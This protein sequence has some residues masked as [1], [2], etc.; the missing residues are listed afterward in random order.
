MAEL[1]ELVSYSAAAWQD[2]GFALEG[3]KSFVRV[4]N[5]SPEYDPEFL[6][7]GLINR[8]V[9][10]VKTWIEAQG[11]TGLTTQVLADPGREPLLV[12]KI[13]GTSSAPPLLIYGHL[14][15]MPPLDPAG[16][17]T[18]LSATDPVVRNGK[19]YGRGTNDD[20][21]NSFVVLSALKYLQSKQ[22]PYPP[23]TLL[24]ETG[25]ESGDDEIRRYLD[26]LRP[27][28][29]PVGVIIVL[30]AEAQD[31]DTVWCCTSLRGVVNGTLDIRHLQ[32]PCHSGMATGLVPSTFRIARI[33]LDRIE[34]SSTGQVL[35]TEAFTSIPPI[36]VEQSR[37][38]AEHLGDRSHEIVTPLPGAQLVTQDN[39]QLL[40]NKA[41][42][43]GLAVTGADGIPA[44]VDGSNVIRTRTA[45]KLSLRIPPLVDAKVV[46]AALK[47]VL[48]A[49]PPY[50]ATVTYTASG[51]G[52]GWCGKDLDGKIGA[53]VEKAT[54]AVFGA[55]PLYYGEGGSIPLLNKFQDLWPDAHF[56]VTGC[57]GV[58]S[59]P[60]GFNESLDL[61]YT[62]KFTAFLA[63][64]LKDI[65]E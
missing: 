4:P 24:L 9:N 15:K 23:I 8:A 30:D 37:Q 59:N 25:E 47:K 58:D 7:N 49:D 61:A 13:P 52:N 6:T 40:V 38:I 21:Y 50:G 28:I 26:E 42:L 45:L 16:W 12:V 31:Y 5:V 1:A 36:R 65:V 60:H 35:V 55:K 27:S 18:G 41:W 33:L 10:V 19:V 2:G 51:A 32:T 46:A 34:N 48:E 3:L 22:L 56:L 20:G 11:I 57:A 62:G 39:A 64:L 63:L 53:A 54:G 43:P 17:D 14:D 44:I 29:G